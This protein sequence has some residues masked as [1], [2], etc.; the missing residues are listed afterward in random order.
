MQVIFMGLPGAGKGTQAERIVEQFGIPHISTGD[1]FRAAM[2]QGTPLGL[3]AK[4][5]VDKGQLV[6]DDV[7]IGIVRER[8]S[9]PD[10]EKGFLLDGFPRTVPQ[11]EALDQALVEMGRK[12]DVVIHLKVDR[13]LLLDRLT[14]R[15]ICKSCGSTYHVIFN[16]PQVEGKCDKCGGELYQ[17]A[18]DSVETVATRLDVNIKQQEPLLHYYEGKGLLR[19]VD[20]EAEIDDVFEQI[21]NILR[22][23]E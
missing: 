22:G 20:G 23:V 3:K 11:A 4:E 1:I 16:P 8:L 17:R 13:E 15:R 21:S 18:D 2:S 12:I 10:T 14:G 7:T 6:P 5:Y 19:T 9:Q